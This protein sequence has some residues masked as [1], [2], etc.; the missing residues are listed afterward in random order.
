MCAGAFS[1]HAASSLIPYGKKAIGHEGL[2]FMMSLILLKSRRVLL[3]TSVGLRFHLWF[4]EE[5]L[6]ASQF[7]VIYSSLSFKFVF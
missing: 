5:M 3:G 7:N 2:T 4:L 6:A 1:F